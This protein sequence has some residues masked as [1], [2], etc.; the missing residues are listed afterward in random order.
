MAASGYLIRRRNRVGPGG[1][2]TASPRRRPPPSPPPPRQL[3]LQPPP[4]LRH[5]PAVVGREDRLQQPRY[6]PPQ[7]LLPPD[8]PVV[9]HVHDRPVLREQPLAAADEI[10][11]RLDRVA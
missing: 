3:Q 4:P 5:R 10:A 8:A 9:G 6:R 2:G 1:G 11:R 7:R